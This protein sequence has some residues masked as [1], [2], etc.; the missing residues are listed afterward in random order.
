[1]K[2]LKKEMEK[3]E[4]PKSVE[5]K[6]KMKTTTTTTNNSECKIHSYHLNEGNHGG[7]EKAA[8]ITC[9]HFDFDFLYAISFKSF[10]CFSAVISL[11]T[12]PNQILLHVYLNRL[13]LRRHRRFGTCV[14]LHADW[15]SSKGNGILMTR[16]HSWKI[17]TKTLKMSDLLSWLFL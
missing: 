17:Q 2:Q 4:I 12:N 9:F 1:M 13:D 14:P 15:N 10:L 16:A 5:R 6:K 3:L 8:S 11:K 7:F